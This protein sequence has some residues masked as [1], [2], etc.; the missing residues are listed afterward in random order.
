[1]L[2]KRGDPAKRLFEQH[3]RMALAFLGGLS[4]LSPKLACDAR[5]AHQHVIT[6]GGKAIVHLPSESRD[7]LSNGR[8]LGLH[9]TTYGCELGPHLDAY[10]R[11]LNVHF[12]TELQNLR[13]HR[14]HA[15]TEGSHLRRQCLEPSHGLLQVF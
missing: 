6:G 12:G 11:T 8:E 2:A 1:V 9:V 5:K 7:F 10:V 14:T 3:L 15:L 13:L 4:D